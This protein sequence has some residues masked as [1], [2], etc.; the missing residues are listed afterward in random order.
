MLGLMKTCAQGLLMRDSERLQIV[1]SQVLLWEQWHSIVSRQ[2]MPLIC[3][4]G[5]CWWGKDI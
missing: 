1:K 5:I 2:Y 3:S 4:S